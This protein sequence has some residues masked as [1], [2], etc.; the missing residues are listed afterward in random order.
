MEAGLPA[1][2]SQSFACSLLCS[3][4]HGVTDRFCRANSRATWIRAWKGLFKKGEWSLNS[5]NPASDNF[6]ALDDSRR[7][8]CMNIQLR[9]ML[10][11]QLL[12]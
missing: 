11:V 1:D 3:G 8:E 2:V 4:S 10:S 12:V 6:A 9:H 7:Q 5:K